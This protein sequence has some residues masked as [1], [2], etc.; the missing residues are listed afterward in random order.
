VDK[1]CFGETGISPKRL[2]FQYPALLLTVLFKKVQNIIGVDINIRQLGKS[3]WF[4]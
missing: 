3:R 2:H 1:T 4:K